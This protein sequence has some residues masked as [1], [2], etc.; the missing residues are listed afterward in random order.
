[1][2]LLARG[3]QDAQ[4]APGKLQEDGCRASPPEGH[5]DEGGGVGLY[6]NFIKLFHQ[7]FIRPI[8][9]LFEVVL[10][11]KPREEIKQIGNGPLY[12]VTSMEENLRVEGRMISLDV[13][14]LWFKIAHLDENRDVIGNKVVMFEGDHAPIIADFLSGAI[15]ILLERNYTDSVQMGSSEVMVV[16]QDDGGMLIKKGLVS[17]E[18]LQEDVIEL[19]DE[20]GRIG[21]IPNIK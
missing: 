5:G 3:R 20:L 16:R 1:M 14:F 9:S 21:V 4:C 6:W 2:S 12:V 15:Q 11:D 7:I 10:T 19:A 13:N 18:V 8:Y 17:V